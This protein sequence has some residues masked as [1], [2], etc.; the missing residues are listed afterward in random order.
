MTNYNGITSQPTEALPPH[1]NKDLE[2]WLGSMVLQATQPSHEQPPV[3]AV[4]REFQTVIESDAIVFMH[5]CAMFQQVPSESPYNND[6][7]GRPQIRDYKQMLQLMNALLTAAPKWDNQVFQIG[8]TG[9]PINVVLNWPMSTPSGKAFFLHDRVNAQLRKVL[10]TWAAHLGSEA[11]ANVLTADAHGWLGPDALAAMEHVANVGTTNLPFEQLF[12]CNPLVPHWGFT[13]WDDF[14]IRRFRPGVRPVAGPDDD[15]IIA[16]PCESKPYRLATNVASRDTFWVKGQPYSVLDMLAQDELARYFIGGTVYQAFLSSLSYHR[17]HSP[18]SGTVAKTRLV[19]GTYY[20]KAD[21][22]GFGSRHKSLSQ[23]Q[24]YLTAVATRALI[25]IKADNPALGLVCVMPV[26]M[27]EVSTCEITVIPGQRVRKGQ[28]L[29][30]FHFGGSTTC[31]LFGPETVMQWTAQA[32][33]VDGS[34]FN[35][36]VNTEIAR[37]RIA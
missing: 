27:A 33:M 4:I 28:E 12:E 23:S 25:F 36:P 2:Q 8:W 3:H 32:S 31:L 6:P 34:G 19:P 37:L 20:S 29:G 7:L 13:S 5:A 16:N 24:G 26:G 14:F 9:F 1:G 30:M 10:N 21:S 15:N 35:I 17:W 11:S 18:V 22:Q